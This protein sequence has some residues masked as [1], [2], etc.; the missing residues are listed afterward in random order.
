M[1]QIIGLIIL[2]SLKEKN[3][4]VLNV[5]QHSMLTVNQSSQQGH[6]LMSGSQFVKDHLAA[7]SSRK[8]G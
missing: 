8:R 3:V 4:N 7:S 6:D 2:H 5:T 1:V